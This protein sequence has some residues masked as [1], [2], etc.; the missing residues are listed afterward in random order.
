MIRTVWAGL[1]F[2][3]PFVVRIRVEGDLAVLPRSLN[4]R[5]RVTVELSRPVCHFFPDFGRFRTI[6]M[7]G[8]RL[9]RQSHVRLGYSGGPGITD[10]FSGIDQPPLYEVQ[11]PCC[12]P[13]A[14]RCQIGRPARRI[15][16][17]PEPAPQ[18]RDEPAVCCASRPVTCH[19]TAEPDVRHTVCLAKITFRNP[20]DATT[21]KVT[22]RQMH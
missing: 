19:E 18:F 10:A 13:R 11:V 15:T 20:L 6:A 14:H 17:V 4:D 8:H 3:L 21:T 2:P 1:G 16:R 9:H 22:K 5:A 7:F 12:P